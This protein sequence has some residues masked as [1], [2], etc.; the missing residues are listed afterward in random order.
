M[1]TI[2]LYRV[3]DY[4]AYLGERYFEC[5]WICHKPECFSVFDSQYMKAPK[6]ACCEHL[7]LLVQVTDVMSF[8]NKSRKFLP[9]V[10]EQ[11]HSDEE[12]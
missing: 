11:L 1:I 6:T 3:L 2:V 12:N 10:M 4:V 8:W 5:G 9:C 7:R